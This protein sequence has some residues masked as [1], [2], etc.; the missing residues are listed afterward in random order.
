MGR[1]SSKVKFQ[2]LT[3]LFVRPIIQTRN[4][5]KNKSTTAFTCDNEIQL[6]LP[7][8]MVQLLMQLL[9]TRKDYEAKDPIQD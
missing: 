4:L 8:M 9:G 6:P 3:L 2:R 7:V 5:L 1:T